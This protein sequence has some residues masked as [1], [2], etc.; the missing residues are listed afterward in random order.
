MVGEAWFSSLE[1]IQSALLLRKLPLASV[2]RA[3]GIKPAKG[4][5]GHFKSLNVRCK[6]WRS[7]ESS[8]VRQE[9]IHVGITA[10]A[11][12][13]WLD[14]GCEGVRSLSVLGEWVDAGTSC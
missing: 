9:G 7:G 2:R 5:E 13:D 8:E 14:V 12:G 6:G 4:R 1:V 3:D 11:L 10:R